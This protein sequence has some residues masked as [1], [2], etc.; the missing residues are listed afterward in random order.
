MGLRGDGTESGVAAS[1]QFAGCLDDDPSAELA[2]YLDAVARHVI[3]FV[4]EWWTGGG[5]H[6]GRPIPAV[7]DIAAVRR[8]IVAR[9]SVEALE[10]PY[11]GLPMLLES[12]ARSIRFN[13]RNFVNIHPSPFMPSIL[14]SMVTAIQNPNNILEDMS[15]AT[16]GMERDCI[17]WLATNLLG[18]PAETAWGNIV[19]GGTL[20]NMTAML[21]ARDRAY[22]GTQPGR[23]GFVRSRGFSGMAPGTV[24]ATSGTHFSLDKA[25]WVLGLGSD[26]LL[27]V[28]VCFDECLQRRS[29]AYNACVISISRSDWQDQYLEALKDDRARGCRELDAF[30]GGEHSPFSLQPLTSGFLKP[31]Y[32]SG[33]SQPRVIACVLTMGTTDTGTIEQLDAST[34]QA[35]QD[36]DVYVHIDAASGGFAALCQSSP[37]TAELVA[38]ADSFTIDGHK[39]GLLHYPCSAIVF[40]DRRGVQYLQQEAPSFGPLAPTLEGSRA[41]GGAALWYALKT[42]GPAGYRDRVS[43]LLDFSQAL[44]RSIIASGLYQILH[45][46]DLNIIS[47]APRAAGNETREQLNGYVRQVWKMIKEDGE[48]LINMNRS[49]CGIK[50]RKRVG[51]DDEELA[52]IECLRIVVANPTVQGDDACRLTEKLERFLRAAREAA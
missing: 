31:L 51:V 33:E 7:E 46:V 9:A 13:R 5:E 27:R 11:H 26:N 22:E 20:A 32:T 23:Y 3:P 4:R 24:L 47:I 28:P 39:S 12:L 35:L 17:E 44:S 18:L 41:G 34:A 25:L 42:L 50:V 6:P 48:F 40:K 29:L 10:E 45:R 16:W 21:V 37:Q 36:Q 43:R 38:T 19:S 15:P 52:D 8:G 14:A 30:Y 49:L 2:A 1:K